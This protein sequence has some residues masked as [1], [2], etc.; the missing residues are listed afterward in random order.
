MD[1]KP[2]VL[3]GDHISVAL[4]IVEAPEDRY[5]WEI[6]VAEDK[7][8]EV[9]HSKIVGALSYPTVAEADKAGKDMQVKV[10]KGAA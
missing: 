9:V 10:V 4:Y 1:R 2:Y 5:A 7:G 6:V 3:T 8:T